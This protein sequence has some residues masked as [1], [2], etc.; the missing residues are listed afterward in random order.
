[1]QKRA[2]LYARVSSDERG[3][4]GR[5]LLIVQKFAKK[6]SENLEAMGDDLKMKR[7]LVEELDVNATLVVENGQQVIYARCWLGEEVFLTSSAFHSAGHQAN[8]GFALAVRLLLDCAR[9]RRNA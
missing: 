4:D 3:R 7:R 1:M 9:R 6:V 8:L 5:N 2:V